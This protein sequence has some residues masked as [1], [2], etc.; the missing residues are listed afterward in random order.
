MGHAL[1]GERGKTGD[2][3]LADDAGVVR[4]V[5]AADARRRTQELDSGDISK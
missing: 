4:Q 1:A 2:R 3:Q 5:E